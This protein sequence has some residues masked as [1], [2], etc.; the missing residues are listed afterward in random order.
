MNQYD[1]YLRLILYKIPVSAPNS[2]DKTVSDE[3]I[4]QLSRE[5]GLEVFSKI[6]E[7]LRWSMKNPDYNFA[8][9]KDDLPHTNKE[10]F[11]FLK[12]VINKM[13]GI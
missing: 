13:N 7:S 6:K 11:H 8:S 2:G 12:N 4:R 1:Q 5:H 9:I 3:F 10:I